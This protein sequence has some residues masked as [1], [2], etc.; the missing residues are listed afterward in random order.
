MWGEA[1]CPSGR[2]GTPC[3]GSVKSELASLIQRERGSSLIAQHKAM[4]FVGL[5]C[6]LLILKTSRHLITGSCR[7][8][9]LQEQLL[10]SVPTASLA[11]WSKSS[12]ARWSVSF[13]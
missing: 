10:R 4:W 11:L 2:G 6:C 9:Q 5:P 3:H 13:S 1:L 12:M 8:S 7:K